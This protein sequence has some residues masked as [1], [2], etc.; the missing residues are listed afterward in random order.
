MLALC[1]A[2]SGGG[3]SNRNDERNCSSMQCGSNR[4]WEVLPFHSL[5]RLASFSLFQSLGSDAFNTRIVCKMQN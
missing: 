2:L 3:R 4:L 1:E 5:L